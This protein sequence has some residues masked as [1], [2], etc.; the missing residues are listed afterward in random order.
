MKVDPLVGHPTFCYS[1]ERNYR[2][3]SKMLLV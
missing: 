2:K 1:R 3:V